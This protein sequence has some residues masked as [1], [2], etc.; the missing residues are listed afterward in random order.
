M[1]DEKLLSEVQGLR[2]D[3]WQLRKDLDNFKQP[4]KASAEQ[5]EPAVPKRLLPGYVSP[6]KDR[7][8]GDRI[9]TIRNTVLSVINSTDGSPLH[10]QQIISRA[11]QIDPTASLAGIITVLN[12]LSVAGDINHPTKNEYAKK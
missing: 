8:R 12:K 3:I 11:W 1:I 4:R 10:I 5:K 6:L 7:P 2:A 9:Q